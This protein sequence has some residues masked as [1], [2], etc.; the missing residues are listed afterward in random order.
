VSD[1][2]ASAYRIVF[3]AHAWRDGGFVR[4]NRARLL[5]LPIRAAAKFAAGDNGG[6]T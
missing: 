3:A 2:L 4:E 6:R 1:G 5:V